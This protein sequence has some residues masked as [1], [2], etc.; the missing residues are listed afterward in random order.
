MKR[1]VIFANGELNL[2]S[3]IRGEIRSD[4][5]VIAA[6]GGA[7]HCRKLGIKPMVVIGDFDSVPPEDLAA[8][9]AEGA[10]LMR[11][12]VRKD[13]TDLELAFEYARKQSCQ[14]IILFG[15]LGARWDMSIANILLTAHP[16]FR[17]IQV[18]LIDDH[19]ELQ[20]L[21]SGGN[22]I[23]YG[24][25]GDT[26]SLIPLNSRAQGITTQGLEYALSDEDLDFASSRGVSNVFTAENASI[27]LRQGLLIC[28]VIRNG[29]NL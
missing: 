28:V 7:L 24:K 4:D 12:P 15:A 23:L 17:E 9:Q 14:E 19:Q 13:E 20:L 25:P 1:A 16:N 26:L 18:R 3:A 8:L 21:Q 11:Y 27:S 5:L 22:L 6:D 29:G 2:S 10:L